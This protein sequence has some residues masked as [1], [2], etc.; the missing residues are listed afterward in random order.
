MQLALIDEVIPHQNADA[1]EIAVVRGHRYVVRKDQY[2]YGAPV[3]VFEPG[4]EIPNWALVNVGLWD[5]TKKKGKL[6]GPKGNRVKTG[7]IR[8]EWN[9]G[10][11]YPT[12]VQTVDGCLYLAITLWNPSTHDRWQTIYFEDGKTCSGWSGIFATGFL[13]DPT[14]VNSYLLVD[15]MDAPVMMA[16]G[17]VTNSLGFYFGLP[18]KSVEVEVIGELETTP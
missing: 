1:L 5:E 17:D 7:N 11:L 12:G 9:S 4:E 2:Q 3:L 8:D 14:D 13:S 15:V 6:A 10:L 18:E 16:D